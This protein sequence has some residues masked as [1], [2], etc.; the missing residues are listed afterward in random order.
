MRPAASWAGQTCRA[1]SRAL[2]IWALAATA[3]VARVAVIGEWELHP[4]DHS[5][6]RKRKEYRRA[7][8]GKQNSVRH[9]LPPDGR[10][11]R[12]RGM[13][14]NV[15]ISCRHAGE[16][17]ADALVDNEQAKQF[18]KFPLQFA[19]GRTARVLNF[20]QFFERPER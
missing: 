10:R 11:S 7:A 12:S 2:L 19:H 14:F 9:S 20:S 3:G 6:G 5:Q 16:S 1:R 8:D 4:T 13:H 15:Q 17:L 18:R